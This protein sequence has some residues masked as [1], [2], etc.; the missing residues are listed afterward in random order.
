MRLLL[1]HPTHRSPLYIQTTTPGILH[2]NNARDIEMDAKT[3]TL[4]IARTCR[5]SPYPP[6]HE[7]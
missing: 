1:P 7:N 3:G 4:T 6:L 5:A 2:A